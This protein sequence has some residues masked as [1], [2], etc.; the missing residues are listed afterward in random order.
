M[1][2]RSDGDKDFTGLDELIEEIIVDAYGDDEQLWAFRQVIEDNIILPT[3]ALVIG[4]PVWV[5]EIDYDGNERRGLTAKCRREDGSEYVL[6][7]AEVVFPED[8]TAALYIAAY[9]MWLGL[10]PYQGQDLSSKPRKRPPMVAA[11]DI[12]LSL[13]FEF[14]VHSVKERAARCRLPGQDKFILF[15]SSGIFELVPGEIVKVAPRKQWV[16]KGYSYLSG[17]IEST[18]L[19]VGAL[20][21]A[22]LRLE[23]MGL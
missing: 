12:D 6:P 8:S 16:F 4:E 2:L 14:V 19:D 1:S 9:R 20:G 17:E 7:A 23:K 5:I 3:D 10:D 21:L 22:P 11:G 15:R 13:S 18:R